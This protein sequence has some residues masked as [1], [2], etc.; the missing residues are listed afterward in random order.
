MGNWRGAKSADSVGTHRRLTAV[1]AAVTAICIA[2][3]AGVLLVALTSGAAAVGVAGVTATPLD[4]TNTATP[5]DDANGTVEVVVRFTPIET[6]ADLGAVDADGTSATTATSEMANTSGTAATSEDHRDA[7]V[8]DLREHAAAEQGAFAEFA[9]AREGVTVERKLWLAN[10]MVVTVDTDAVSASAL[11][12]VQNVTAVHENVEIEPVGGASSAPSGSSTT[13]RPRTAAPAQITADPSGRTTAGL[14]QIDVPAAWERFGTRGAGATVAVIDTGADSRHQDIDL[15]GWAAFDQQGALVSDDLAD[16][17]DSD[18]HGTHVAGTVAGGNASGTHIGVAPAA[19]LHAIDVFAE[20][21][22]ATFAGVIAAM[23]YATT[24]GDAD[25][26]QMSLGAPGAFREFVA[27]V[28]NARAAGA[29]VVVAAGNE[30]ENTSTS[31]GNVHDALAVGA[32]NRDREVPPFSSGESVNAT[33]AFET[34]PDDWPDRYVVPDVT[35]PGVGV[36][37]A[38]ANTTATYVQRQGTS[39]AAPH[40]AGVAALAVAATDGRVDDA[41]LQAAI[42]ETAIHPANATAPDDRYGHGVVDAPAAVGEAV[43]RTTP[44]PSATDEAEG[45]VETGGTDSDP[46]DGGAATDGATPGFGPV[47]ALVALVVAAA[48]APVGVRDP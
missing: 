36:V 12:S 5:L 48:F 25:V 6:P 15:D 23:E 41:T 21:E 31:P 9:A 24:D 3:L 44:E 28:R 26:L 32:V 46:P 33:A 17:G 45:N 29:I 2:L 14:R 34:Y 40:V 43:E 47:P 35:A 1:R 39:M 20:N 10:A 16:A 22:T 27:P 42:V 8:D 4:H 7:V 30:G 37:S 11:L 19:E 13:P 18:G 38:E